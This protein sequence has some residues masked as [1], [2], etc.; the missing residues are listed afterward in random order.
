M[1]I[2]QLS[3]NVISYCQWMIDS[4]S[5]LIELS[6]SEKS[7]TEKEIDKKEKDDKLRNHLYTT[8]FDVS[9]SKVRT[10]HFKDFPSIHPLEIILPPPEHLYILS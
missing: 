5:E 2:G 10:S 9:I 1:L 8:K 7:E 3:A 4:K 6:N